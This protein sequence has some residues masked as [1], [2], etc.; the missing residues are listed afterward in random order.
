MATVNRAVNRSIRSVSDLAHYGVADRWSVAPKSGDCE[1]FALTKKARLLNAGWPSSAL[2]LAL[3]TTGA[4]EEHAVLI[5]RTDRGDFVLDNLRN[6]I[7][8]WSAGLYRWTA[9]QSPT[10]IW[11]WKQFGRGAVRVAAT[12]EHR[13][14]LAMLPDKVIGLR[15]SADANDHETLLN[16]RGER[17][18]VAEIASDVSKLIQLSDGAAAVA[19]IAMEWR[20]LDNWFV[21]TSI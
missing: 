14:E 4:G 17:K 13:P 16:V 8:R 20:Q 19:K 2:L 15:R 5:V 1:D 3:A 6:D 7:R 10:D 11:S 18:A 21:V 9:I 12:D